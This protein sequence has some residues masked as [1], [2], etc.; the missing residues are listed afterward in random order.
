GDILATKGALFKTKTGELSIFCKKLYILNKSLK[1]LP[2]KFHGLE[3]QEKR[4][5]KRYLDLISNIKL[6]NVFKNRS[7]I[8]AKI[9]EFMLENNFLEVETP[10]LQ[11]IP[12]GALAKPFI[13]Y[14]NQLN[15]DM[16]LRIAPELY[17]K[18]LII[19]GFE[20]IFELN[21]NFRN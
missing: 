16:Y 17:L 9:R 13:T 11:N 18:Q 19:G 1:P 20:R 6:F 2:D 4:Y 12:G 8:I 15:L 5:R 21:R 14:H 10:M 3:N 7:N